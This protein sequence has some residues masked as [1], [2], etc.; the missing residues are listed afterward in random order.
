MENLQVLV[1]QVL[2]S[3]WRKRWML[4]ATAWAVCLV[5]WA[6][7][8]TLPDTYE[9][10]ARIY[11]DADA[12]LNPLL[13]GLAID[14]AMANQLDM[15]QRTLL[16]RPNLDKL[17]N[18]TDLNISAIEPQQREKLIERL[19]REIKV[20]SEGRNLF[21]VTYRNSNPQLARDVVAG[22]VTIFMEQANASNRADMG[23]AQKF[24][25]Q[26]ITSYEVQLRKAEQRRAEF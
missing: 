2:A 5:G 6:S 20:S 13:R 26:Q 7:V 17:I 10:H 18:M 12:I 15:M 16:S 22:L 9:S 3:A 21:T 11:V 14:S 19:G 1:R 4:V 23:N 8:S 24:L 25:N